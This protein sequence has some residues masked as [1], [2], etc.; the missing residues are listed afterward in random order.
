MTDMPLR[1]STMPITRRQLVET[2][3]VVAACTTPAISSVAAAAS[4]ATV[5]DPSLR[6]CTLDY[7]MANGER[8]TAFFARPVA[9]DDLD[10]VVM[11][12]GPDGITA[13][14]RAT[15]ERHARGGAMVVV[16]DLE[17]TTGLSA[18]P[19][20]HQAMQAIVVDRIDAIRHHPQA[21]GRLT[22]VAA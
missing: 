8:I 5:S 20:N 1:A 12:P 9:R 16:P 6:T 2:A 14:L 19:G 4:G 17:A 7:A 22:I 10:V 18:T 11:M 3:V 21:S 15:A 13:P